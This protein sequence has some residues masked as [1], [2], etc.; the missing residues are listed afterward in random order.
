[1]GNRF[2]P[3]ALLEVQPEEAGCMHGTRTRVLSMFMEWAKN[4]PMRIFWLAGLAGTG[5]TSIAVTLSRMLQEEPSVLLGGTFFCSRTAN[6]PELTDARCIFPTLATALSERSTVFEAALTKE[7]NA[8]SRVTLKPATVQITALLQQPLSALASLSRSIVFV[9]DALDECSDEHEVK[10]LL[11]AISTLN[12]DAKVKFILTS[13]PETHINTSLPLSSNRNS[14]LRLHTIDTAEVTEDIRIYIDDAFSKSQLAKPWYSDTD[15]KTLAT[16]SDGLFIFASTI[17]AYIL[18]VNSVRRRETRLKTVLSA[19]QESKVAMAPLDAMYEFVLTRASDAAKIE[20]KE[21]EEMLQVLACILVARVPLSV[22]ALA[23]LL[24][25]ESDELQDSLQRLHALVHVPDHAD[26]PG[27]RT[28]HASFGDYLFARNRISPSLGNE[29]LARG[30]LRVMSERLRF[31]VCNIQSSY[32]TNPEVKP[33]GVTLSLEYACIHWIYHAVDLATSTRLND[34]IEQLFCPNFL[35]WLEVMSVLG[36]ISRAAAMLL[37]ATSMVGASAIW[38]DVVRSLFSEG[39][40]R[41]IV[42]I[43]PRRPCFC[44]VLAGS[45]RAKRRTHLRVGSSFCGERLVDTS[46]V[47]WPV[48]RFD[49]G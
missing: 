36:R 25:L 47:Y 20:P 45:D 29:G 16:L 32:E 38:T 8:D 43:L 10:K 33:C 22:S 49:L 23:D 26:H 28:L 42:S 34:A 37:I 15:I 18:D 48:H 17:I 5:K 21:L 24:G 13:R 46:T 6:I 11:L 14:I 41:G 12:C 9:I 30:S 35:F 19:V 27:L 3:A 44:C 40:A 2:V 1:M 4:D 7:L 31:N 39:P